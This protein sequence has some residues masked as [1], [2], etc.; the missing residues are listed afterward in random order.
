[1]EWGLGMG[2]GCEGVKEEGW[3]GELGVRVGTGC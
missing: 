3:D 1:M 2:W